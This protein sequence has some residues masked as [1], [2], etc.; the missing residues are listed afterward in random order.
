[1]S[2]GTDDSI[3]SDRKVKESFTRLEKETKE[4]PKAD[5]NGIRARNSHE[6]DGGPRWGYTNGLL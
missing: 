6:K 2:R 1:M 5:G 4:P 3:H